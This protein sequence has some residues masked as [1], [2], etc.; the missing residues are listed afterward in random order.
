VSAAQD[1]FADPPISSPELA[2]VDADLAAQ[3]R[4]DLSSGA[5]F[6]P[7]QAAQPAYL[8]LVF[9]A[10]APELAEP[11]PP[12]DDEPA[13]LSAGVVDL[14]PAYVVLPDE[15]A[16]DAVFEAEVPKVAEISDHLELATPDELPD[17]IVRSHEDAGDPVPDDPVAPEAEVVAVLPEYIVPALT[18]VP[19]ETPAISDY[20][21]LP[22]LE[23]RSEAL[24]ETEEALRRIRE[25]LVAPEGRRPSRVRRRFA[26]VSAVGVAAALAAV[27]V[28]IQLG[29]LHAPGWLAS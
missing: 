14:L 10:A 21:T 6:Q 15:T 26:I 29:L 13:E 4:A 11:E 23:A 5:G 25:Q 28:D 17:Y 27:A 18:V 12:A 16:V 24:E 2:L 3:L 20:P 8:S 22:D 9:D 7:C 19:E 1:L